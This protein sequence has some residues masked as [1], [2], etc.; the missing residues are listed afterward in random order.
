MKKILFAL[1]CVGLS[2]SL[3]SCFGPELW[4]DYAYYGPH[5]DVVVVH[6]HS[7][8]HHPAPAPHHHGRYHRY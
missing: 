5:Y 3:S 7:H 2:L 1:A 4:D 6:S 8:H